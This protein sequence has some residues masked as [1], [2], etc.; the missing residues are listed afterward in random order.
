MKRAARMEH[1]LGRLAD[2]SLAFRLVEIEPLHAVKAIANALVDGL[3]D[4]NTRWKANV[5]QFKIE[6]R[7]MIGDAL[8]SAAAPSS[9][10]GKLEQDIGPGSPQV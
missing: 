6:R 9:G 1:S 3:A 5:Q 8:L 7:S 4:E 2:V 10:E